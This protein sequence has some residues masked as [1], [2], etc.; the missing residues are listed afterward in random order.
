M[1]NKKIITCLLLAASIIIWGAIARR[2]IKT[3]K[4]E[5]LTVQKTPPRPVVNK[6]D[7]I[8]L[9]LNYEDPFLKKDVKDTILPKKDGFVNTGTDLFTKEPEVVPGPAFKFKGMV[10][11]GEK[12][13]GLLYLEGE[14]LMVTLREK[15]GDFY[16]ISITPDKLIVRR[17]GLDMELFAE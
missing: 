5:E 2:L 9:L 12:S 8:M 14:T 10:K 6:P 16:V 17:K 11:T 3:F 4:K 15:I 13:Y 1:K 7:S